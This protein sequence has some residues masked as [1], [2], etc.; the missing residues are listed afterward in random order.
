MVIFGPLKYGIIKI[1]FAN[2]ILLVRLR[3]KTNPQ[4]D[5]RN[6]LLVFMYLDGLKM[7]M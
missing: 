1:T 5:V 3:F 6:A 2:I 7:V 4:N